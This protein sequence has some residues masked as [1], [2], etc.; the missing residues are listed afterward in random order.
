MPFTTSPGHFPVALDPI[1]VIFKAIDQMSQP[2]QAIA[3]QALNTEN[4]LEKLKQS[5]AG[6][7]DA[8]K[9]DKVAAELGAID[10]EVLGLAQ[11]LGKTY[12][13]A[14]KLTKALGLAPAEINKAVA[15]I[16]QMESVKIHPDAQFKQ[17][18]QSLNVSREQFDQLRTTA[19]NAGEVGGQ[20]IG[21]MAGKLA[22]VG[23]AFLGLK[24]VVDGVM[25]AISG[26][27]QAAIVSNEQLNAQL[28]SSQTNLASSS[29][30]FQDGKEITGATEKIQA[31]R[32]AL[33]GAIKTIQK[34]TQ[35]LVGVTSG[36][37]NEL[38]QIT[39]QNAASLNNQAKGMVDKT[40]KD[41]S[42]EFS[43]PIK[44]ATKLT[45]G[46]AAGLKV[47]GIPLASAGQEINSILK[48]QVD[49]NSTLAKNLNI[50]NA[51]VN[52][53]KAQ[54]TLVTELN[55]KLNV[56][57]EGNKIAANSIDGIMSN[58]QDYFELFAKEVGKPLLQP[59]IDGLNDV[60]K[61]IDDNKDFIFSTLTAVGAA[62]GTVVGGGLK[63]VV[64]VVGNAFQGLVNTMKALAPVA[65]AVGAAM[66]AAFSVVGAVLSPI[67]ALLQ[68]IL[69]S[70]IGG[71]VSQIAS[72][73]I[74][75]T[76]VAVSVAVVLPI[77]SGVGA[78]IAGVVGSFSVFGGVLGSVT[79]LFG[80]FGAAIAGA[81]GFVS[82]FLAGLGGFS[83]ILASAGTLLSG[84]GTAIVGAFTG[85]PALFMGIWTAISGAF[86]G[87][88]VLF[89]GIW[90]AISGAFLGLPALAT[91]IWTA[92]SGAFMGFLSAA[93][94]IVA[95]VAAIGAAIAVVI[96]V[97]SQVPAF[98][99]PII[100][101]LGK[102]LQTLSIVGGAVIG[103]IFSKLAPMAGAAG[104]ALS[105][106]AGIVGGA[107]GGAFRFVQGIA[108]SF[109]NGLG[110]FIGGAIGM[111]QSAVAGLVD[112]PAFQVLAKS[113][114][115][116]IDEVK[117]SLNDLG[118]AES[119]AGKASE[120]SAKKLTFK[121]QSITDL[122]NSYKQL[123][124]K[125][126]NAQ[127]AIDNE[128]SG[129]PTR[130]AAAAKE[131]IELTQKQLD[132]GQISQ[133]EADKRLSA[134]SNNSKVEVDTQT[135][136]RDAIAKIRDKDSKDV[137]SGMDN[138]I[139]TIEAGVKSKEIT[140]TEGAKRIADLKSRKL[141]EQLQTLN[142]AI[143]AEQAAIAK[144][145]GSKDKLEE[146]QRSKKGVE[147]EVK[148][149]KVSNVEE[150][151]KAETEARKRELDTQKANL[152]A[153]LAQVEAAVAT[154][155]MTDEQA[156]VKTTE[157]KKQ[158]LELQL[159]DIQAQLAQAEAGKDP[160]KV[161]QLQ[162]QQ[163][164]VQ[165]DIVKQGAEGQKQIFAAKLK[166][167]DEKEKA[168]T[169]V[170][171]LAEAERS[172]EIDKQV[173]AGTMT[174]AQAESKKLQMT[175]QSIQKEIEAERQ[176][177]AIIAAMAA[178]NPAA[179]KQKDA[180]LIEGK[181]KLASLTS[182]LAQ[183]EISQQE[184][185]KQ[186]AEKSKQDAEQKAVKAIEE[187]SKAAQNSFT[188]QK[189][190]LEPQAQ[191]FEVIGKAIDNQQK[192]LAARQSLLQS[193]T[194]LMKAQYD[195]AAD[196]LESSGD[197]EGAQKVRLE[198]KYAEI[199]ALNKQHELE[200]QSLI[201]EQQKNAMLL[202][203]EQIRLRIQQIE[204]KAG[205]AK[206]IADLAKVKA[207]GGSAE[208]V[209]AAQLQVQAS[210]MKEV[211]LQM[212]G[213]L[214]N[215]QGQGQTALN[216]A[217]LNN[218]RAKQGGESLRAEAGLAKM[219]EGKE[220]DKALANKALSFARV[221]RQDVATGG[222]DA[223]TG[224]NFDSALK[225]NF[226]DLSGKTAPAIAQ[227]S[228]R[229]ATGAV[230]PMLASLAGLPPNAV[231]P[232]PTPPIV[233]GVSPK[234]QPGGAPPPPGTPPGTATPGGVGGVVFNNF[235]DGDP[236]KQKAGANAISKQLVTALTDILKNAN[237]KTKAAK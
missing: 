233:P 170:V 200:E 166:D 231:P 54:G 194:D 30:I 74:V 96:A 196:L 19:V 159:K 206:A 148:T 192:V 133:T 82:T 95:V 32:G 137:I 140:E 118:K 5:A 193:T 215:Q 202:Q 123:A 57:A 227:V 156:A 50:T 207:E 15:S 183:N 214:L 7:G 93:A 44:A 22:V 13:E 224:Q 186:A 71:F 125:A 147:A 16:K 124:D 51:Q 68:G 165:A 25:G 81:W 180:K 209:K 223:V 229:T 145:N 136:A 153:Q 6:F 135:A 151:A 158:Q 131:L 21:G 10:G 92:V 216:E 40:G 58:I 49:S 139:K 130:F 72:I 221:N 225:K 178:D 205:T 161:A 173:A 11:A 103:G 132:L 48:G 211:G 104:G 185:L 218:L 184:K 226:E 86:V 129:D 120:E 190:A 55:K 94:P 2:L 79:G 114:G 121:S 24:S 77:L 73:A 237:V 172:A 115:I 59:V 38:F 12:E 62:L 97:L 28:L 179:Q 46:W 9:S 187:R 34:E 35:S 230:S 76:A 222:K 33:E 89:S 220:D 70:P 110:T 83:G 122:G 154:G 64:A 109:F 235:F 3:A 116:N 164:K 80:G 191:L 182:Q 162:A 197:E 189:Q 150:I 45:A 195:I 236:K 78:A 29:R 66:S 61:V 56:F 18:S 146:L 232:I 138:E 188:A 117:K 157:I 128:G 203:Q 134:I 47:I 1:S 4:I 37:V 144:G 152:D 210:Q 107:L 112:N 88:P 105:A 102:L 67:G 63:L 14:E 43:D 167:F 228:E 87:L 39:L 142:E 84:F 100:E 160:A 199:E 208:E 212:Q 113:L 126:A 20:G 91:G 198:S 31:T 36:Q 65:S 8:F 217:Q 106:L 26:F 101:P 23:T 41:I 127:A 52:Q 143:S 75:F 141:Q 119:D 90:T 60:F 213:D 42:K 108:F 163:T 219:T 204:A 174:R 171:K 27:Y 17:L 69:N 168:A 175:K 181:M 99:T 85:L 111:I 177:L 234:A 98:F 53:W 169:D 155:A 176:K 201:L 149:Q